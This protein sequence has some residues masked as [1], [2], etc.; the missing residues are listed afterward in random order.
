MTIRISPRAVAVA[1][2]IAV[3]VGLYACSTDED[4]GGPGAGSRHEA[5]VERVVD[6][7]TVRLEGVGSVRLIG[8]DTPEVYG[9]TVECFGPEASAF[10]KRLLPRGTRV[11]YEVG[12]EARDRYGRLLAYVFLPDG[13]L[14]NRILAERG[15]ATVLTIRPND[16]YER[17]FERAVRAARRARAG[18]WGQPGCAS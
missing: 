3:A 2:V 6:G 16:R 10:A 17:V 12:R 11:R 1:A 18:M 7:D 15:Y 5:R 13:R 9:Q 8:I 14:V 4:E